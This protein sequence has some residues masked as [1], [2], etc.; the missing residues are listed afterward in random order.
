MEQDPVYGMLVRREAATEQR[1]IQGRTCYF[2]SAGRAARF[3]QAPRQ[4]TIEPADDAHGEASQ[5]LG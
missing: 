2:W 5:N 1:A 4:Y 3:D